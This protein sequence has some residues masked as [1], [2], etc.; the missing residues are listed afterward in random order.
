MSGLL[1][2]SFPVLSTLKSTVDKGENKYDFKEEERQV[3]EW[4]CWAGPALVL[5]SVG[6]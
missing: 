4:Q 2:A 3:T 6:L 1:R 5:R